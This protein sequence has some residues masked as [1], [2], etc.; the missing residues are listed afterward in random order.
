MRCRL[1]LFSGVVDIQTEEEVALSFEIALIDA[2]MAVSKIT[3]TFL[4]L[5]SV[6]TCATSNMLFAALAA[7]AASQSIE[8]G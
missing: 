8:S 2:D 5:S 4:A 7:S 1:A 6:V 3:W